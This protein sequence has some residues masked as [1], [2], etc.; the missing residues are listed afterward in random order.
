MAT[1]QIKPDA[2]RGN[3]RGALYVLAIFLLIPV[4]AFA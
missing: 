3:A 1:A 4:A 2:T